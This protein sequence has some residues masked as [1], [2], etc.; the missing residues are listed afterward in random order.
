MRYLC[1]RQLI[2]GGTTYH[3]GEVIPDGVIL[4]ERSKKLARSGYLSNG[5]EK[6]GPAPGNSKRIKGKT[7]K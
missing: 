6:T 2:A 3:P 5:S 4:P 1:I 7:K